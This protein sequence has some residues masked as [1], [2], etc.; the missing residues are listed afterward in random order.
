MEGALHRPSGNPNPSGN[1]QYVAKEVNVDN[2]HVDQVE[3]P[4]GTSRAAA[5]ECPYM[6]TRVYTIK[7]C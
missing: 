1:N 6:T 2:I 3:R 5:I 7:L 4:T